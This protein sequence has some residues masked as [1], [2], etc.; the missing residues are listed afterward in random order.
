MHNTVSMTTYN[1][2]ARV[3]VPSQLIGAAE[4][5]LILGV[6]RSTMNRRLQRGDIVPL[7]KIDGPRGSYI[8]DRADIEALARGD[9]Q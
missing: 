9:A 5:A 4:A 7:T 6:E 2:D 1:D 3:I 8:F